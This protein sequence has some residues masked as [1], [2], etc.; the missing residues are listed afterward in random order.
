[1]WAP[2]FGVKGYHVVPY[3]YDICV[4]AFATVYFEG[5]FCGNFR[6]AFTRAV[7]LAYPQ[8]INVYIQPFLG[9]FDAMLLGCQYQSLFHKKP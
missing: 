2:A 1:L 5:P 3:E 9:N 7:F 4:A 6:R 8:D